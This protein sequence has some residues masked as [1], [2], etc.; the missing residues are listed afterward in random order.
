MW[1]WGGIV[2]SPI[3]ITAPIRRTKVSHGAAVP[4]LRRF[5]GALEAA[6]RG[7][8]AGTGGAR[9]ARDR[10]SGGDR[11]RAGLAPRARPPGVA[12]E[13]Q[14]DPLAGCRGRPHPVRPPFAARRAARPPRRPVHD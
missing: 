4:L 8:D 6:A 7:A 13:P 11:L 12:A 14:A 3:P 9:M 5:R 2:L 10:R 1:R